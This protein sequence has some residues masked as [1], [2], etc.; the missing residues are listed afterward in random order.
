MSNVYD[1]NLIRKKI[2]HDKRRHSLVLVKDI[3]DILNSVEPVYDDPC[4]SSY[5]KYPVEEILNILNIG[6]YEKIKLNVNGTI[7]IRQE[8]AASE[9]LYLLIDKNYAESWSEL[10]EMIESHEDSSEVYLV[11]NEIKLFRI[12]LEAFKCCML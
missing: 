11:E 9:I 12:I 7:S 2:E 10:K 5:Y 6:K 8:A 1:I 3:V 4:N